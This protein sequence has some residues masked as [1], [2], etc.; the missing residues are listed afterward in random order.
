MKEIEKSIITLFENEKEYHDDYYEAKDVFIELINLALKK[1]YQDKDYI[2]RMSTA[3]EIISEKI[4]KI[5]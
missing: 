4:L 1:K 5:K 2:V 3:R